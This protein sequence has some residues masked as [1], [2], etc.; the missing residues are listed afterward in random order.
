[1]TAIRASSSL[2]EYFAN[3]CPRLAAIVNSDVHDNDGADGGP[4]QE[5]QQQQQ[6]SGGQSPKQFAS[7]SLV[8]VS[9]PARSPPLSSSSSSLMYHTRNKHHHHHHHRPSGRKRF[10]DTALLKQRG[11]NPGEKKNAKQFDRWSATDQQQ[12]A[13]NAAMVGAQTAATVTPPPAAAATTQLQTKRHSSSIMR[14]TVTQTKHHVDE[15]ITTQTKRHSSSMM[16]TTVTQ[17]KHH[18]DEAITTITTNERN[19]FQ[20]DQSRSNN[21]NDPSTLPPLPV[22]RQTSSDSVPP[23]TRDDTHIIVLPK[24]RRASLR[25]YRSMDV[26]RMDVAPLLP[27]SSISPYPQQQQRSRT[28]TNRL[29]QVPYI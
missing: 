1:M 18:V 26:G 21:N 10:S 25:R 12:L 4:Q 3:L 24:Q 28:T 19:H 14:T 13:R 2:D 23:Q 15:A 9:D 22:Q 16:R 11:S 5:Q 29:L 20:L 7:T 6:L 8:L 27:K 17:T